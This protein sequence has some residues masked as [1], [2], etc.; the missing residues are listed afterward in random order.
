MLTRQ[1]IETNHRFLE[2]LH[3]GSHHRMRQ[4]ILGGKLRE[5]RTLIR[6]IAA[7][8]LKQIPLS[9]SDKLKLV[10]H[11]KKGVLRALFQSWASV[12]RL[13]RGKTVTALCKIL[14]PLV[15]ILPA[16]LNAILNNPGSG[17][18]KT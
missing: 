9:A 7:V 15:G 14:L 18:G 4:L 2:Q 8:I 5:L 10:R 11:K 1:E 6:L 12:Q 13:L 3:G 17:G 16:I